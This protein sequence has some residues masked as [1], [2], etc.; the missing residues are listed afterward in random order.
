MSKEKSVTYKSQCQNNGSASF[1]RI[2]IC[3][4]KLWF[5]VFCDEMTKKGTIF[6]WNSIFTVMKLNIKYGAKIDNLLIY[7]HI[8]LIMMVLNSVFQIFNHPI[9]RSFFHSLFNIFHG[10]L[11]NQQ[12]LY[13]S[14]S[15]V[16]GCGL[17]ICT[18]PSVFL[19]ITFSEKRPDVNCFI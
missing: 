14:C 19:L 9:A 2:L 1:S 12:S 18:A 3:S 13:Y 16:K 8:Y 10:K 5:L 17:H 11:L 7:W 4:S 6:I 15:F